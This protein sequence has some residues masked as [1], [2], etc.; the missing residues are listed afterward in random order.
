MQND[1]EY[2]EDLDLRPDLLD[3]M[4]QALQ[5]SSDYSYGIARLKEV[6]YLLIHTD[7]TIKFTDK[8]REFL[9]FKTLRLSRIQSS[10][11]FHGFELVFRLED[12]QLSSPN[13]YLYVQSAHED[14][15]HEALEG[16]KDYVQKQRTEK[17]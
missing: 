12:A 6:P 7:D 16:S 11:D 2:A 17:N 8:L 10:S 5:G 9:L 13:D 14:P 4:T 3:S 15:S 1:I